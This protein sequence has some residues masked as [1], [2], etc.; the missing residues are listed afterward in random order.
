MEPPS[1]P[2]PPPLPEEPLDAPPRGRPSRAVAIILAFALLGGSGAGIW[3]AM[4]TRGDDVVLNANPTPPIPSGWNET[5]FRSDGFAIAFPPAWR[6]IDPKNAEDALDEMSKENPELANLV[7]TQIGS[8]SDLIRLLAV[9][10]KSPSLS[11]DFATNANVIV[12][13]VPSG[14]TFEEFVQANAQQL[15]TIPGVTTSLED[16]AVSMPAG[17][18]ALVRSRLPIRTGNAETIAAVSQ[19]LLLSRGRGYI[20]SFT[21]TPELE[22][23]YVSVFDAITRTFR[24]V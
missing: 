11:Q 22:A 9:D 23:S 20:L 10:S 16:E 7:R 18:A 21:T 12:Q 6:A 5:V 4:R 19:Y 24:Y 8:L 3:L 2:P 14:V 13:P 1:L 15:R 17:R